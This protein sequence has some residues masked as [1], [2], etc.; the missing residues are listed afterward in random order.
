MPSV[1]IHFN[2]PETQYY[3]SRGHL[4]AQKP[5]SILQYENIH[6]CTTEDVHKKKKNPITGI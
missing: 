6:I 4:T 1:L 2:T 5:K 3:P